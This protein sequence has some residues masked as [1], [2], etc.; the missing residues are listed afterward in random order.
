M[1]A[2]PGQHMMRVLPRGGSED[3][4]CVRINAGKYIH[5]HALAGDKAVTHCTVDWKGT[6]HFDAVIP[7]RLRQAPLQIL[8]RRPADLVRGLTQ[9]SAGDKNNL[10]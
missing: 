7:E 6:L 5:A 1:R 9:V 3:E 4:A 2:H 8:L 10:L